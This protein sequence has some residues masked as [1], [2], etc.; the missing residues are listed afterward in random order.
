MICLFMFLKLIKS[1]NLCKQMIIDNILIVV[2]K[3]DNVLGIH[4]LVSQMLKLNPR[5]MGYLWSITKTKVEL[6]HMQR[7]HIESQSKACHPTFLENLPGI[8][9]ATR[10]FQRRCEL[11]SLPRTNIHTYRENI[12]NILYL[13]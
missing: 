11:C 13:R 5:L 10:T 4:Y 3:N 7:K 1:D 2:Q 9:L 6:W 12:L 8:S